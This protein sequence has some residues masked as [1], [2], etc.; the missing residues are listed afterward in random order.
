[1]GN[2]DC[3]QSY[4]KSSAPF[5]AGHDFIEIALACNKRPLVERSIQSRD[6]KRVN[7]DSLCQALSHHLPTP[8]PQA[9][10]TFHTFIATTNTSELVLGPCPTSVDNAERI[11]THMFTYAIDT[12]APLR[13]LTL[14]SRRKPWVNPQIRALMRS[15]DRAYRLAR[16]SGTPAD[17]DHFR[18]LHADT[19]NALAVLKTGMLPLASLM[20]RLPMRSG[21]SF[22]ACGL[23]NQAGHVRST[24]S[25]L[26]L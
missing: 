24:D 21:L 18:A 12:V 13:K 8:D 2:L 20:P 16:A 10:F 3:L 15:R 19:S 26:N 17:Y 22:D 5:I 23:Q 7:L 1:M 9:P 11:L 6:L 25:W 4:S 14:S